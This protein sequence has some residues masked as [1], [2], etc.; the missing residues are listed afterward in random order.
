[1]VQRSNVPAATP[2]NPSSIP[3]AHGAEGESYLPK[4][5]FCHPH[6]HWGTREYGRSMHTHIYAHSHA[7][8]HRQ[9]YTC[10]CTPTTYMFF[11]SLDKSLKL[12][13]EEL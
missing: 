8:V 9:A 11:L 5:V 1:M 3:R 10:I 2:D 6:S 4:A 7:Q 12:G 13:K